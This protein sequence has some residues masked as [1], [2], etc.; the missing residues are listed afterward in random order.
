MAKLYNV[1]GKRI[2]VA[3]HSGM[4]GSALVRRL[5]GTGAEVLTVSRNSVDLRRQLAV[6][7]WL[8]AN[9]P[10]AVILVAATVGGIGANRTR[11]VDFLYDNLAI[12]TNVVHA[13]AE[14]G[15]EKLLFLGCSCWYPREAAQPVCEA[16]LLTGP[17]EP[18]NEAFAIAKI[19]SAKLC[20]V[21]R[22]QHGKDFIVAVPTSL[23][24][25]A[26]NFN[27]TDGHVIPSLFRKIR[28]AR[29]S[30]AACVDIWGTGEPLR[31]FLY[32]DDAADALVFLMEHYSEEEIINVAGGETARIQELAHWIAE[33][34]EYSGGLHFDI[35]KPDGMPRKVLDGSRIRALGWQPSTSLRDGL[36]RTWHWFRT[37]PDWPAAPC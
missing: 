8:A 10:A 35:S 34:A 29:E 19:A 26:D 13:A 21:Y 28:D 7:D 20:Q 2:W 33:I 3:G 11:P 23:F 32:V 15:V 6:E 9:R 1:A 16:S 12:S 25:P 36:A 4:V 27:L 5:A 37:C 14:T 22:K 30:G 24:G 17:L 18:T 31:E